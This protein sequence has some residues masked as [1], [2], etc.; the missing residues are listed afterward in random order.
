MGMIG[1]WIRD[2]FWYVA[3]IASPSTAR[4]NVDGLE[5][6]SDERYRK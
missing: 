4:T 2:N 5:K 6:I 1:F 3:E